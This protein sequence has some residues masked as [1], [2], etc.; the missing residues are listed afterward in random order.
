MTQ[1]NPLSGAIFQSGMVQQQQAADKTSQ[2][3][4]NQQLEKNAALEDD[5][6]ENQVES[7]EEI[8]PVD[9]A[10]EQS[11]DQFNRRNKKPYKGEDG[12][13]H[14]DVTA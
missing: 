14:I 7:S 6:M 2:I 1:F 11:L 13:P 9:D 3:R 12:K 8:T 10:D 5:Q 4:R